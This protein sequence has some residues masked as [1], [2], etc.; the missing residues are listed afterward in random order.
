MKKGKGRMLFMGNIRI[1][2]VDDDKLLVNKMEE[3]VDC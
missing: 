2:I 3:T 1:L